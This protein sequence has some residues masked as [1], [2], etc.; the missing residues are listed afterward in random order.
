MSAVVVFLAIAGCAS[1][2]D[3][4][5]HG[6]DSL[7]EG[8]HGRS[9][10]LAAARRVAVGFARAYA[11]AAAGEA[12]VSA[13]G[14]SPALRVELRALGARF[15]DAA[16]GWTLRPVYVAVYPKRDNSAHAVATFSRPRGEPIPITYRLRR[17][18]G[19]WLVTQL[20]GN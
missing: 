8:R 10:E 2:A 14:I 18:R 1:S 16:V 15:S 11:S 20:V 17:V 19:R 7:A 3:N 9:T 12:H 5:S 4:F 6:H 13:P